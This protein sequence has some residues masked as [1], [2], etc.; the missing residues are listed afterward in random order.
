M[1]DIIEEIEYMMSYKEW[2]T[3]VSAV[4]ESKVKQNTLHKD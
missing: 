4:L 1:K 3:E 2:L